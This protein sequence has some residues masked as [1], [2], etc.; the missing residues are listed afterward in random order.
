MINMMT[1][2]SNRSLLRRNATF[3][4]YAGAWLSVCLVLVAISAHTAMGDDQGE[5]AESRR[6]AIVRAVERVGPTVVTVAVMQTRIVREIDPFL[7]EF[8]GPFGFYGRRRK[9]RIPGLGSGVIFDQRGYI[10]TNEHVIENAEK[11]VVTL[12]DGRQFPGKLL[13][14]DHQL[15]IAVLQISAE[16]LP[17]AELGD[18]DSLMLGEWVI[19]V[20][21][22]FG[23]LINEPQPS[24]SVGV[25]SALDRSFVHGERD[26]RL[27]KGMIQTDAAINPGNSGGPLVNAAGEIVGVNTFIFSKTGGYQGISFAISISEVNWAIAE[28]VKYGGVRKVDLRFWVGDLTPWLVQEL[29][30]AVKEGVVV[31]AEDRG[32]PA[33]KAGLRPGDIIVEVNG[34]AISNKDD[35]EL[36]FGTM[37]VGTVVT[38]AV[39]RAGE[40]KTITFTPEAK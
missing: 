13:G 20:G 17:V 34:E 7:G 1:L 22:P 15:D 16:D 37:P 14:A 38:M 24:V 23:F 31:E 2:S 6:N 30:A 39:D 5:I 25:V 26:G 19:A 40:E 29:G 4:P 33:W 3:L 12:P 10:L 9:L 27:Y 28:I 36:V 18:S 11:I 35:T 21:N 8:W 32:S